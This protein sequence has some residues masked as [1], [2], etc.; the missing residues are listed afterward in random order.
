MES[1]IRDTYLREAAT[2]CTFALN[3]GR[4]L[5]SVLPRLPEAARSEDQ[6][7]YRT[8][9]AEVFRSIH[10]LLTYASNVS[11]LFW[12]A[13]P[14]RKRDESR[15]SYRERCARD[16]KLMR[17]RDLR[18]ALGLPEHGH[19]LR[20]RQMRDHLE[21]FDER[22]D[23]WQRTSQHRIIGDFCGTPLLGKQVTVLRTERRLHPG[24][25]ERVS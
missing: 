15:A 22:L 5:N 3:A 23:D 7:K 6:E 17:G 9:H 25:R 8:L 21:H 4:G 16:P 12:P 10:S 1:F 20:S 24:S 2:Q 18:D 19:T 14:H 11:R 13:P